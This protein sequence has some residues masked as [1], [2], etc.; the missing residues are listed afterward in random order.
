MKTI[1]RNEGLGGLWKGT[2][3]S[4]ILV[5]NPSIQ[6]AIYE[7][8]KRRVT[9]T[10]KD[11][12]SLSAFLVGAVAKTCATLLTYPIQLVQNKIRVSQQNFNPIRK[13]KLMEDIISLNAILLILLR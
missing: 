1:A 10:N 12:S 3:A 13:L 2:I 9:K 4:L 11:L 5:C 7:S 8:I 6:F